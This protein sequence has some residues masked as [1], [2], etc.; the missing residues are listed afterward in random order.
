MQNDQAMAAAISAEER[1]SRRQIH[2]A[3]RHSLALEGLDGFL[4]VE[5]EARSLAWVRGE[6]TLEAAIEQTL[7]DIR[8]GVASQASS[9]PEEPR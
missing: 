4:S 6:I 9:T 1:E 2:E 3:S 5:T 8:A 7:Q